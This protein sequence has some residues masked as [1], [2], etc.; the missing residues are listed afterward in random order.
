MVNI[1]NLEWDGLRQ[2]NLP[3]THHGDHTEWRIEHNE[4]K[5]KK[6]QT[7]EAIGGPRLQELS[8]DSIARLDELK[9]GDVKQSQ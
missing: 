1:Y 5:E 9:L 8:S 3:K 4:R 6:K 7:K 2:A